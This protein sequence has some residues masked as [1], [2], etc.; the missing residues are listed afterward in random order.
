MSYA[1]DAPRR[2]RWERLSRLA[3]VAVLWCAVVLVLADSVDMPGWL[4][5]VSPF[6]H[7]PAVPLEDAAAGPSLVLLALAGVLVAGGLLLGGRRD[8]RAG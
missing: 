2:S 7:V 4:R 5:R 3:W 1:D 6:A 8:V